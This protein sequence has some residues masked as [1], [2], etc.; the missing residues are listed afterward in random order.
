MLGHIEHPKLQ[1]FGDKLLVPLL[2]DDGRFWGDPVDIT[3]PSKVLELEVD[4]VTL[5]ELGGLPRHVLAVK[6]RDYPIEELQQVPG[7]HALEQG[8]SW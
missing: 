2:R 1:K 3:V 4:E 5:Y 7:F 6:N 8:A